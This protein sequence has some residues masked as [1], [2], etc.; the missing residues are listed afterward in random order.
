MPTAASARAECPVARASR[1]TPNGACRDCAISWAGALDEQDASGFEV[2]GVDEAEPD[3]LQQAEEV[4]GAL[5]P[6]VGPPPCP[7]EV[8]DLRG[9]AD[10]VGGDPV[11]LG[12]RV[13]LPH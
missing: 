11:E 3:P 1:A 13:G 6:A 4:V 5:E 12:Q 7:V 9:P 2:G 10:D 8:E